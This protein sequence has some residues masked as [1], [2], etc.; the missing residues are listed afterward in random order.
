VLTRVLLTT[1]TVGGVWRYSLELA[2][3]FAC[4]GVQTVL[5]TLGPEPD[6]GQRAEAS[7]IPGLRLIPTN[8]PLDWL[9]KDAAQLEAA[10]RALARIAVEHR[11]SAVHLHTP[12]LVGAVAWPA[13]VVAVA[14]S[15]VGT[16][17]AAVHAGAMPADLAWRADAVARGLEAADA[18]IAPSRSFARALDVHY[19]AGRP[20]HPVLN[21][22]RHRAAFAA[23]RQ[24]VLTAG[25]LW[26]P[27]KNARRLDAAA[28]RAGVPVLAAG[29]VQGPH[30]ERVALRHLHELGTLD[31]ARM[32]AAYAQA[33]VFV[34]VALYEPFG[35]AVLEAAQAGCALVLSAIPTFRELW[36]GAALFV[37][38]DDTDALANTLHDLAASPERCATLGGFARGR[39]ALYTVEKMVAGTLRVHNGI[40]AGAAELVAL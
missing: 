24:Q 33:S 4:T 30:G 34:S 8:L 13:P 36:D 23:R 9:A 29:P 35:L 26:D 17:W 15:C 1:D 11:C 3:G 6:A 21:G 40:A 28:A 27:G 10:A 16:W 39:A 14:H 31:E 2:R 38:P 12:A 19:R 37:D 25:R 22:R 5:V 32:A 18:V 7:S 20:I